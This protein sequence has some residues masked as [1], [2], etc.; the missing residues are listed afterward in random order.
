MALLG[1]P[2]YPQTIKP[3]VE[4]SPERTIEALNAL[5]RAAGTDP[6]FKVLARGASGE[7]GVEQL[8]SGVGGDPISVTL[9]VVNA[10]GV[11]LFD[12]FR[13]GVSISTTEFGA[14]GGTQTIDAPSAGE[15]HREYTA[16]QDVVYT[17][18]GAGK[19]TFDVTAATGTRYM[20][21]EIGGVVFP[22]TLE[23]S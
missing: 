14:P 23:W 2:R 15:L 13:L 22:I 21:V 17:T 20:T 7:S 3:P 5:A 16:D 12:R 6:L 9:Q 8:L 4:F 10:R 18:D 1:Q 11:A 19:V